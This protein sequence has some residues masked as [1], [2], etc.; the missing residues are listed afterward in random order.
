MTFEETRIII[1]EF[2]EKGQ[3]FLTESRKIFLAGSVNII[4]EDLEKLS[5]G[6]NFDSNP[7]VFQGILDSI[8][9]VSNLAL[10]APMH[11]KFA[12]FLLAF[13]ELV[14]NWNNNTYKDKT[15][16][17]L[18]KFISSTANSR[19]IMYEAIQNMKNVV[20]DLQVVK[21]WSPP[22][23]DIALAYVDEQLKENEKAND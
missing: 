13:S 20:D 3:N 6:E 7:T 16:H 9:D 8:L 18:T 15:V 14:Y 11:R 23:F 1:D 2:F 5:K 21:S 4:Y 17:T 22:S 10:D 12:D 19:N